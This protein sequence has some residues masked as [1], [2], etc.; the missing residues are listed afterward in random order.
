[1]FEVEA[2]LTLIKVIVI[3]SSSTTMCCTMLGKKKLTLQYL[4]LWNIYIALWKELFFLDIARAG[5]VTVVDAQ[6]ECWYWNYPPLQTI[7][8]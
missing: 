5:I 4:I 7:M 1:M 8:V 6:I 2:L 3:E